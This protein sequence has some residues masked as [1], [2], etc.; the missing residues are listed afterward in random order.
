M[1]LS[2]SFLDELRSRVTLSTLVGR[3]I[4]ITKAGR[5]FKGC[6]PFHNE[7]TPSFY[8]NDDKGFA[9]CFGC[10]WHGDVI[11]WLVDHD[12]LEF[13]EAVRLL[14]DSAGMQMPDRSPEAAAHAAR[15]DGLR[16]SLDAA[17]AF[18]AQQLVQAGAVR[19]YLAARGVDDEMV[20][21][22]GL[23]YAP[24][25]KFTL[26][27]AINGDVRSMLDAGLL[28]AVDDRAPVERFRD[29]LT[30]PV[31]DARG[32]VIGFGARVLG[33]FEPKYL[34]SPDSEIFDKGRVLFNL[35]RA[36]PLARS[37]AGGG[38]KRLVVVEGYLDVIALTQI[39]IGETVAPMGTALTDAQLALLWRVNPCPILLL[40]GD[41]AGQ[42]AALR[43]CGRALPHLAPYRSLSIA[44]LPSGVD[45]DDLARSGGRDGVED[46]LA[47]AVGLAD[48]VF[49]QLSVVS[50][51]SP[52]E[53]AG[54]W[55]RLEDAARTIQDDETRAQYLGR[56]RARY[57]REISTVPVVGA[58]LAVT[59][60]TRSDDGDYLWPDAENES[61]ARLIS[62]VRRLLK[63][64]D[65]R[66]AINDDIKDV[67]TM[68][69]IAGFEPKVINAAVRMIE[70]DPS[71]RED[72]EAQL[73]VYR[74]A[75]GIKGP[76]TEAM[77]PPPLDVRRA[78]QI[79]TGATKV[80]H[81][82]ALIDGRK[83]GGKGAV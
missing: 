26:R 18:Y 43:A 73:V 27:A 65:D 44:V 6:C 61:E 67:L 76:M 81:A 40:D 41:A 68:A 10:S 19:E 7:K 42:K 59:S 70:Q 12:G 31:H 28:V 4:K 3:S 17:Q 55:Q 23:G 46:V 77:L 51:D 24:R 58:D 63:L 66:A 56:W 52:E 8:V 36:A 11:K 80:N 75:L 64:R 60:G 25:T 47:G 48:F 83:H 79:G 71:S 54:V 14:A 5:E 35:H 33:P 34:N 50:G 9:H 29:R 38:H 21:L 39:G 15:V 32:R 78:A 69:K 30:I 72:F 13:L 53:I 57:D 49:N 82:L 74:R 37:S 62:I 1:S 16:P 22:F 2:Q 45:P 20:A